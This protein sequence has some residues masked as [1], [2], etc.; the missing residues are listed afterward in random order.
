MVNRNVPQANE[1]YA[2]K[3]K[4]IPTVPCSDIFISDMRHYELQKQLLHKQR[5]GQ[6]SNSSY[7]FSRDDLKEAVVV[8]QV[9]SKF[10]ACLLPSG[11]VT[12]GADCGSGAPSQGPSRTL[13]LVDQHAADERVRVEWLQREICLAH[14]RADDGIGVKRIVLDPPVPILLTR[15]ENLVLRRSGDVRDFLASWGVE[16]A[17]IKDTEEDYS[18][19]DDGNYSQVT[20]ASIPEIISKRVRGILA[21]AYLGVDG[22]ASCLQGM[23]CKIWS[24]VCSR[25]GR[26]TRS[27]D[28]PSHLSRKTTKTY[29]RGRELS[30]IAPPNFQSCSTPRLAEVRLCDFFIS[31]KF[32]ILFRDSPGAIMFNDSLTLEQ[33]QELIERLTHTSVPFRCA[34][35][36]PSIVPLVDLGPPADLRGAT[37][38]VNW[39]AYEVHIQAQA[40]TTR[41]R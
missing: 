2:Q 23:T 34:H 32:G 19:S 8:N 5:A 15:H 22:R 20:V 10:I 16:F 17:S 29:S 27:E 12:S 25:I 33:C 38:H 30:G 3:E 13:A 24:R 39:G 40:Q 11:Y 31:Q 7:R 18:P 9:D 41:H 6:I 14:L 37:R 4:P 36:R 35:G 21:L 1:V 28:H 26:M